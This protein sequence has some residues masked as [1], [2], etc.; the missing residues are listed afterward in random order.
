[1]KFDIRDT[2]QVYDC[3]ISMLLAHSWVIF[4]LPL[5]TNNPLKTNSQIGK[6][7]IQISSINSILCLIQ[8]YV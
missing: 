6:G 2:K 7:L 8:Y 5:F 4:N 1:M 3:G